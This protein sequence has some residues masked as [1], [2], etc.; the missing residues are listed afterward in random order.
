[1]V[2]RNPLCKGHMIV[3]YSVSCSGSDR[4]E[5]KLCVHPPLVEQLQASYLT[6]PNFN[7]PISKTERIITHLVGI[8]WE[9]KEIMYLRCLAQCLQYKGCSENVSPYHYHLSSHSFSYSQN[10][11]YQGA[12][13]VKLWV[14]Q[15]TPR[16]RHST[17]N[18][19]SSQPK[20]GRWTKESKMALR[21]L[22]QKSV[23]GTLGYKEGTLQG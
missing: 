17:C 15:R 11:H 13:Q 1:M 2:I 10:H 23:P 16:I 5:Q 14:G 3:S 18:T 6:Q 8:L 7:F 20:Q 9:S 19:G 21:K 12:F 4:F 22:G